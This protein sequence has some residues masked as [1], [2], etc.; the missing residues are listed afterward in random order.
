MRRAGGKAHGVTMASRSIQLRWPG[1]CHLCSARLAPGQTASFDEV[2]RQLTCMS[3]IAT[4]PG[5]RA[6]R[7]R[8]AE[9]EHVRALIAEARAALDR[10]S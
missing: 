3:C 1:R 2:S 6:R 5:S 7:S 9:R 4:A 10:A 8:R